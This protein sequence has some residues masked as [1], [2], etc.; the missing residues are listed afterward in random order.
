MT[1]LS[2][3]IE[4][5]ERWIDDDPLSGRRLFRPLLYWLQHRVLPGFLLAERLHPKV[6]QLFTPGERPLD[7]YFWIRSSM[8]CEDEWPEDATA[9]EAFYKYMSDFTSE[10]RAETFVDSKSE[11]CVVTMPR[12]VTAPE[13]SFVALC[14]PVAGGGFSS[15]RTRYL[16]VERTVEPSLYCFSEW[17]QEGKHLNFGQV[18]VLSKAAFLRR[19]RELVGCGSG[20]P[21]SG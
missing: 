16:T 14:R 4:P 11:I 10:T 9:S 18:G 7:R 13:A 12:P 3:P 5:F 8:I 15:S 2:T 21:E 1:A 19:V 6:R 20:S 17:T